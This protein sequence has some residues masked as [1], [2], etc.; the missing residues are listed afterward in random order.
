LG[1]GVVR[2]T[3][4][5]R[6]L[7][8][9]KTDKSAYH[10]IPYHTI[11]YRPAAQLPAEHGRFH[12]HAHSRRLARCGGIPT[13]TRH[14][15]GI[16]EKRRVRRALCVRASAVYWYMRARARVWWHVESAPLQRSEHKAQA[17]HA[18]N[19]Q[20]TGHRPAAHTP[21]SDVAPHGSPPSAA[22]TEIVRVR[23]A[24]PSPQDSEQAL[25]LHRRMQCNAPR[26]GKGA[27]G[28]SADVETNTRAGGGSLPAA[29]VALSRAA[30]QFLALPYYVLLC[31]VSLCCT[32]L[33][34]LL[35]LVDLRRKRR[36][37]RS[38]TA[39]RCRQQCS[40]GGAALRAPT[41]SRRKARSRRRM[42]PSR[43]A[44]SR[45]SMDRGACRGS[46]CC[47]ARYLLH[48]VGVRRI[49]YVAHCMHRLPT[50]RSAR[51]LTGSAARKG[52]RALKGL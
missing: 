20:S 4:P 11:P 22:R 17:L 1:F 35:S 38:P 36:H 3:A 29:C 18:V 23:A 45:W 2:R 16:A 27:V 37:K 6:A 5:S 34:V 25:Q 51:W 30:W 28:R 50:L 9:R 26:T 10:T 21:A 31:I 33:C 32:L 40:A 13:V 48:S 42:R 44:S 19:W 8:S 52:D 41:C 24:E 7:A 49:T 14:D 46:V 15:M 12:D 47:V 43:K 39:A